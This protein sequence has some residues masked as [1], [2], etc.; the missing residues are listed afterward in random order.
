MQEIERLVVTLIGDSTS[1]TTMINNAGNALDSLKSK[2]A[3]VAGVIGLTGF[4][5]AG[6]QAIS[7]ASDLEKTS[8]AFEV[9]LG[10]ADKSKKMLEEIR[11]YAAATP[12]EQ[13]PLRQSAQMLMNYGIAAESIM[14]T[15]KMLG[16]VSAGD[17]NKLNGLAY[18]FAQMTARGKVMGD[19]LRQMINWGFNPLQEMSR[20]SGKSMA[21]LTDQMH[22]GG[23]TVNML[24][25]AFKSA[26]SEGG[27]FFGMMDKQSKT[28]FGLFS[29]LKDEISQFLTIVGTDIIE[30]LDIKG[31]VQGL[32]KLF[33][34]LTEGARQYGKVIIGVGVVTASL[35][36]TFTAVAA[37][38]GLW[39]IATQN[40]IIKQILL[41]SLSGPLGWAQIAAGI[42]VATVVTAKLAG[43][44]TNVEKEATK[45]AAA[46]KS[47]HAAGTGPIA[48][49]SG[50]SLAALQLRMRELQKVMQRDV[51]QA[52]ANREFKGAN[53][54]GILGL[55]KPEELTKAQEAIKQVTDRV[56]LLRQTLASFRDMKGL[57]PAEDL[58]ILEG[59]I[60]KEIVDQGNKLSGVNELI[61]KQ[62]EE[63]QRL[64]EASDPLLMLNRLL[65][66]GASQAKVDELASKMAQTK[67]IEQQKEAI[68]QL[69]E[70]KRRVDEDLKSRSQ[71]LTQS[72]M[73]DAEKMS[74]SIAEIYELYHKGMIDD[75]T[76]D[77]AIRQ[78]QELGKGIGE[79]MK[80]AFT[81]IMPFDSAIAGSKDA[82]QHIADYQNGLIRKP[83][84]D[85]KRKDKLQEQA[86]RETEIMRQALQEMNN[87]FRDQ[88][89]DPPFKLEFNA[90][91]LA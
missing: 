18:A 79:N 71:A 27:R 19:D 75:V 54:A 16:E 17:Q 45:A 23:I 10:S 72:V 53:V 77:R 14:P 33:Q 90:A 38:V 84:D 7:L 50:Q 40:L 69:A 91:N 34:M 78:A 67:A 1:Y 88:A 63:I 31:A 13:A 87:R 86:L 15:L 66:D 56:R 21:E 81:A 4:A 61:A 35:V 32:I 82:A 64:K 65:A 58:A 20:T 47:V 42:A 11:L 12:F 29:T 59:K 37:A 25:A 60:N 76:K 6:A 41:K 62:T 51:G 46:V 3:M 49:N 85:Q 80:N 28:L 52:V 8:I 73:T 30:K 39:I 44:F 74:A 43:D 70:A 68:E 22:K 57:I 83:T 24:N 48:A 2:V 9:M 55:D 89:G 26:S 5:A 36:G